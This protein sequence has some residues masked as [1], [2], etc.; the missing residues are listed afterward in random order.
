LGKQDPHRLTL[1]QRADRYID[2]VKRSRIDTLQVLKA[3]PVPGSELA[4]RLEAEGRIYPLE[5]VGWDKYDGNFL[6]YQPD[7][8][9]NAIELQE[10]AI[11][12]M[13][14]FYSPWHMLKLLYLGPLSP[15]DWVFYFF[16]RGAQM[17]KVKRL[18]FEERY[19]RPLP[20]AG[21]WAAFFTKGVHGAG[22]E[23]Y[24]I[25]RNTIIRIFGSF[26]L[27]E[28][29]RGVNLDNFLQKLKKQQERI[30]NALPEY[31]KASEKKTGEAQIPS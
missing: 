6:C 28:W 12:I 4:K 27:R 18:E 21:R 11:R 31:R 3:V 8:G 1:K 25:W 13:R 7:P 24:R 16:R 19:R 20:A 23:I 22:V 14:E 2:F 10:E 17:L 29:A 15:I 30:S 26:A 9:D 5:E